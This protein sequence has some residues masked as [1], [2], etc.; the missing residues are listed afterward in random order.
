VRDLPLASA[1]SLGIVVRLFL[2]DH[3]LVGLWD[4]ALLKA[5]LSAVIV[6]SVPLLRAHRTVVLRVLVLNE[7]LRR[8]ADLA[9]VEL[10]AHGLPNQVRV[11]PVVLALLLAHLDLQQLQILEAVRCIVEVRQRSD[12][13]ERLRQSL[14]GLC[15]VLFLV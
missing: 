11:D 12:L 10:V 14:V 15:Q 2:N 1:S 13:H 6:E 5:E 7:E 8:V 9:D 4:L 3:G